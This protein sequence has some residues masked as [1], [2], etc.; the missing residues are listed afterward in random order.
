MKFQNRRKKRKKLNILYVCEP[1]SEHALKQHGN[2][3]YWGYTETDALK[4]F[5]ENFN[6]FHKPINSII[7]RLH[8]VRK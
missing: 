3:N 7:I 1:I 4:Y 8:P 6:I 5:L 2:E